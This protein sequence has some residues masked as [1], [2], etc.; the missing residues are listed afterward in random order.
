M[1]INIQRYFCLLTALVVMLSVLLIALPVQAS[2][3]CISGIWQLDKKHSDNPRKILKKLIRKIKQQQSF[4]YQ[5]SIENSE[6]DQ[7]APKL[8]TALPKFVFSAEVIELDIQQA[9]TIIQQNDLHRRLNTQ[10]QSHSLSLK[11][12]QLNSNTTVAS[13][14]ENKLIVETTTANGNHV[15]E[16]YSVIENGNLLIDFIIDDGLN[17]SIKLQKIY[18]R[19]MAQENTQANT[20]GLDNNPCSE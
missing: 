15:T 5:N 8:P 2:S 14:E 17:K 13:W 18:T 3:P 9:I 1:A 7:S 10:G 20:Q 12:M 16:T 11:Q 4:A 6:K 19:Q